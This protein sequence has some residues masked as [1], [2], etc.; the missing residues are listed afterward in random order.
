MTDVVF[1]RLLQ[2]LRRKNIDLPCD[3]D[4]GPTA[5]IRCPHGE[6][7]PELAPGAKRLLVSESLWDFMRQTAMT[8]KPDDFVGCSAFPSDSEP[9]ALCSIE[10][11]EAAFSEDTLRLSMS[12]YLFEK[13]HMFFDLEYCA[14]ESSS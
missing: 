6:L 4:S 13:V 7:M 5:S 11:T 2:W 9:C 3:A 1:C 8:V 10:L 12:I 14:A